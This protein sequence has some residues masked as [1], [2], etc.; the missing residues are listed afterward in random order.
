MSQHH[1]LFLTDFCLQS[2]MMMNLF[3]LSRVASASACISSP[4]RNP[5]SSITSE[6]YTYN[7]DNYANADEVQTST[8][9]NEQILYH[10]LQLNVQSLPIT[11]NTTQSDG[12]WIFS[13]TTNELL[14]FK[15]RTNN[16]Q[17][18]QPTFF[19][20][21]YLSERIYGVGYIHDTYDII[22][23]IGEKQ[24]S[25]YQFE[26]MANAWN[27][28][29]VFA[30]QSTPTD[31][32]IR[33]VEISPNRLVAIVYGK[34][35]K[36]EF[37]TMSYYQVTTQIYDVIQNVVSTS[38]M[39]YDADP[40][41]MNPVNLKW[42]QY[43]MEGRLYDNFHHIDTVSYDATHYGFAFHYGRD[44][45]YVKHYVILP[46][47]SY[48]P[49]GGVLQPLTYS[50]HLYLERSTLNP[51]ERN[52]TI[53]AIT[54]P[55]DHPERATFSSY[56]ISNAVPVGPDT[57]AYNNTYC[58]Q[59][60]MGIRVVVS[61]TIT[62]SAQT[63]LQQQLERRNGHICAYISIDGGQRQQ[64]YYL[65]FQMM[66]E[67]IF[68]SIVAKLRE[69]DMLDLVI[70]DPRYHATMLPRMIAVGVVA[71]HGVH[72]LIF[73]VYLIVHRNV[74]FHAWSDIIMNYIFS[75]VSMYY[76][77]AYPFASKSL[78]VANLVMLLMPSVASTLFTKITSFNTA[79]GLEIIATPITIWMLWSIHLSRLVILADRPRDCF[80]MEKIKKN[81][82]KG[83]I[84]Y[85]AK[86]N[87]VL[88]DTFVGT[89]PTTIVQVLNNRVSGWNVIAYVS[90]LFSILS[91]LNS[92]GFVIYKIIRH[93]TWEQVEMSKRDLFRNLFQK[94]T[95]TNQKNIKQSGM[96]TIVSPNAI[97]VVIHQPQRY[98]PAWEAFM[99]ANSMQKSS[100]STYVHDSP[101]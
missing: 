20:T 23:I 12:G 87:L 65:D 83:V 3:L 74:P 44:F 16:T 11:Y 10:S 27:R 69:I 52:S 54:W 26:P 63:L 49:W 78:F 68:D 46:D 75:S 24:G 71:L 35:V 22:V 96:C 15:L 17:C 47:V 45:N 19:G 80:D 94:K 57:N 99:I 36:G 33:A 28:T 50:I 5:A 37:S 73:I 67:T 21:F 58:Y 76:A 14:A 51:N 81:P 30:L 90:L 34:Y 39:T 32:V 9:C 85:V 82:R 101:V 53:G 48:L 42:S 41:A 61:N 60:I 98:T 59:S 100:P 6:W 31:A 77:V 38:S 7:R 64:A 79:S 92:I 40:N 13:K 95:K 4:I 72:A 93:Q 18:Y 29:H 2:I 66:E 8:R 56:E 88:S 1:F 84:D 91:I 70:M 86:W 89:I 97:T 25:M 43:H 62:D 55:S